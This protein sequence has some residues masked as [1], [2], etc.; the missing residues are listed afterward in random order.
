MHIMIGGQVLIKGNL[1]S[2]AFEVED[3][4]LDS[5]SC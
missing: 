1:V 5:L 3:T 4:R 2:D